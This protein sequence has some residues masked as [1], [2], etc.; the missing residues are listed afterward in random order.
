MLPEALSND[1]C[2]LVPN[3][4]RLTMSAVFEITPEGEVLSR[5]FGETVIHSKRR[6]SYQEAQ[7]ILDAGQGEL[8]K[9]LQTADMISRALRKERFANGSIGFETDEIKFELDAEGRPVRAFRKERLETMMM[10]EDLMLLANREVATWVAT[11]CEDK[12]IPCVFVWR[13]HDS[14]KPDRIEELSLFLKALGYDL[15]HKNGIVTAKAINALFDELDDAP[16]ADMIETATIRSMAKA[17]YSTKNIGHFG[18]AFSYYTHFT[19]PIRRYP[20][21]MV[22][23]IVKAHNAGRPPGS[24]DM[25]WHERMCVQSSEREIAAAEAERDSIKLKQVEYMASH[26][27]E[28]FEGVVTGLTDYGIFVEE[29]ATKAEGLVRLNTLRDDFYVRASHGYRLSG[30]RTGKTISL[31]DKVHVRLTSI[32]IE[33]KQINWEFV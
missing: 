1:L 6:F 14:P 26:V 29:S 25:P 7:D 15:P 5:W 22:H 31:G 11:T 2:S 23:R 30:A 20:D 33:Q 10:I 21:L 19:S 16:E 8:I 27:G 13:I 3:E 32:D 12:K 4:D 24:K 17:I 9:E 28:K 18:L